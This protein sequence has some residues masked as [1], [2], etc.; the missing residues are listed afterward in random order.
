MFDD[1]PKSGGV[2][3]S[4]LGSETSHLAVY[5]AAMTWTRHQYLLS[6]L[7]TGPAES[8]TP[9]ALFDS[10]PFTAYARRQVKLAYSLSGPGIAPTPLLTGELKPAGAEGAV[11]WQ[12][13]DPRGPLVA[14]TV[15]T[16]ARALSEF[17][18][19]ERLDVID[20]ALEDLR[21][22]PYLRAAVARE[23]AVLARDRGD[24]D[25]SDLEDYARGAGAQLR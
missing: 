2:R 22:R 9:T 23:L 10:L 5:A 13:V 3:K 19:D 14:V 20:K 16:L 1:P 17:R 12:F 15:I 25:L 11:G 4:H 8:P 6:A 18:G 24:S 7:F 21:D